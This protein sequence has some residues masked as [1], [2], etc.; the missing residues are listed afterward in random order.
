MQFFIYFY[1]TLNILG[2]NYLCLIFNFFC[3]I[4][5]IRVEILFF[6]NFGVNSQIFVYLYS[7]VQIF[8]LPSIAAQQIAQSHLIYLLNLRPYNSFHGTNICADVK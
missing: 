5:R 6:F 2:Y 4:F 7:F 3:L 1:K 8:L